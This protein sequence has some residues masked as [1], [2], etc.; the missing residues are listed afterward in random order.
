MKK[1]GVLVSSDDAHAVNFREIRMGKI[2]PNTLYRSSHQIK[3]ME[4]EK[5]ISML[6]ANAKIAAVSG[7][8]N[9]ITSQIV[10]FRLYAGDTQYPRTFGSETNTRQ[11]TAMPKNRLALFTVSLVSV[12]GAPRLPSLS[13]LQP[14]QEEAHYHTMWDRHLLSF[15]SK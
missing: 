9:H 3:N 15:H 11:L 7:R 6:A 1:S 5:V 8:T 14:V 4:Q 10:Y 2:A 12:S 13:L